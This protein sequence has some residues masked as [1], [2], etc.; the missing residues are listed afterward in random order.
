MK[1]VLVTCCITCTSGALYMRNIYLYP[2]YKCE[3][4][5][6]IDYLINNKFS[7]AFKLFTSLCQSPN[8]HP[9]FM[10]TQV[11]FSQF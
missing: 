5:H 6:N 3:I 4:S 8:R 1:Q 9:H 2:M 7:Q 10:F 11:F